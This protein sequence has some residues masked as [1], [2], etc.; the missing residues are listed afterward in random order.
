MNF[1]FSTSYETVEAGKLI[2]LPGMRYLCT[3]D[4]NF[5]LFCEDSIYAYDFRG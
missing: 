3:L 1:L 2:V 5:L 4:T